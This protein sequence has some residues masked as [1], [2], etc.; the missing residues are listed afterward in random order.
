MAD[1]STG[2][3]RALA[4]P[5]M[6][7]LLQRALGASQVRRH[8]VEQHL[9]PMP[10]ERILDLG[11]GPG[12]LVEHLPA[13][14][15]YVG[16]DLSPDY[17]RAARER[18]GRRGHFE[19]RDAREVSEAGLGEFDAVVAVGL[20]HHLDAG[21]AAQVLSAVGALLRA[22]GRFVSLDPGF[23]ADQPQSARWL[24]GRDRGA[25]I[26][27]ASEYEELLRAAFAQ[28]GLSVR[29]DLARVPYTH[30]AGV[31]REPRPRDSEQL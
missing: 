17:V 24:M 14:V 6:Y 23:A 22:G 10:G 11:C 21:A 4:H 26:R 25:H 2:V 16:V 18:Y 9:R 15:E 5:A 27:P 20:L 13:T 12:D 30:I 7:S 31:A 3:R 19:L 29:H 1:V 28:V 8:L